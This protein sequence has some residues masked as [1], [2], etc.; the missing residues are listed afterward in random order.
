[1]GEN[2][3]REKEYYKEKIIEVVNN[4]ERLDILEYL[5]IFIKGKVGKNV[6]E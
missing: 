2:N 6:G 4:I 1:M 5:Y 3:V